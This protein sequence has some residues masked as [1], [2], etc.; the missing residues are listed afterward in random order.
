MKTQLITLGIAATLLAS[1]G[2]ESPKSTEAA[3]Q[4]APAQSYEF[5]VNA[6]GNTMSD[7]SYDTKELKVKAGSK[8]KVNL[9]NTGSDA[10]MLHNIVFVKQGTEKDVAMEG[11]NLKDQNYFNSTNANVIAGSA[12][13]QPGA[14]VTLEFTAPEAGTYTYICTYPG[15][16]QKMQGVLI[17]E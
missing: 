17:V 16:W 10:A 7:M 9:T 6:V 3:S 2:G 8:V 5:T 11:I 14:S 15:H 13:A 1:C 12:V 4:N